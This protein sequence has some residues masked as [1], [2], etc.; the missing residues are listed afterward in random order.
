MNKAIVDNV[1]VLHS[2]IRFYFPVLKLASP[3]SIP[4]KH[5]EETSVRT[6]NKLNTSQIILGY[7]L[8]LCRSHKD[9]RGTQR[10]YT[11]ERFH[12]SLSVPDKT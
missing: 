10:C 4:F 8:T 7:Y 12:N 11:K 6:S 1:S 5:L 9:Y 3:N 2:F